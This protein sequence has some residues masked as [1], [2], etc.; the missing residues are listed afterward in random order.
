M[1]RELFHP[2]REAIRLSTLFYALSEPARLKIV[3]KL[4]ESG[5]K[6]CGDLTCDLAKSTMS[7]HFKVLRE[8]GLVN[9]RIEGTQR[10]IS[11]R[12]EDLEYRFQGFFSFLEH[13]TPPF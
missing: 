6:S 4:L 13:A 3:L 5:E 8:S 7:H 1:M 10:F 2:A 12:K 11:I 9:T